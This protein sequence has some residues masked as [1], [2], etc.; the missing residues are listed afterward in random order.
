MKM[1]EIPPL[2]INK[3]SDGAI[4]ERKEAANGK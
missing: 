1:A 2:D 3:V 4:T